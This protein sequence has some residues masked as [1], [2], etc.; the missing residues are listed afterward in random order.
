MALGLFALGSCSP[1]RRLNRKF[2]RLEQ[3]AQKHELTTTDTITIIEVDTFFVPPAR[4]DTTSKI[5]FNDTTIVINNEHAVVKYYYD[6]I[7]NNI[8]HHLYEKPQ[9]IIQKDTVR[10][11]VDR[12]VIKK[13]P[14][15]KRVFK[16]LSSL[17]WLLIALF[18]GW[19]VYLFIKA[20]GLF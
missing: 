8:H 7:T 9:T 17:I 4:Y 6:T 11:P 5:I 16:T 12:V 19:R 13:D 20:K 14:T 3:F 10:V 1:Q 15:I 18:V 2:K